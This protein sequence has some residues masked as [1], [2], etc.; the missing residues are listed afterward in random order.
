MHGAGPPPSRKPNSTVEQL[1]CSP[2]SY[3]GGRRFE[4]GPCHEKNWFWIPAAVGNMAAVFFESDK[5]ESI[6]YIFAIFTVAVL[7]FWEDFFGPNDGPRWPP[8]C[9]LAL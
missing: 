7:W 2:G 9:C 5:T 8:M 6:M 1:E 3:P 4:S